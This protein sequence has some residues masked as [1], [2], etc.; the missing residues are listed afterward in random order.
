MG[1]YYEAVAWAARQSEEKLGEVLVNAQS[2]SEKLHESAQ[3]IESQDCATEKI[4]K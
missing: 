3:S 4:E 1:N 2:R